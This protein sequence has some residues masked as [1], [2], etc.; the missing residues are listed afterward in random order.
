MYNMD[1]I[2]SLAYGPIVKAYEKKTTLEV[3]YSAI[4]C[5]GVRVM[6]TVGYRSNLI[7]GG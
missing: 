4:S 2:M 1:C 7:P 6:Y 3:W 5:F